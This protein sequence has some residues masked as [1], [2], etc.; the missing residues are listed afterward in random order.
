[1]AYRIVQSICLQDRTPYIYWGVQTPPQQITSFVETVHEWLM[2]TLANAERIEAWFAEMWAACHPGRHRSV[3]Q[4][5]RDVDRTA[6]YL[7]SDEQV[8]SASLRDYIRQMREL[9]CGTVRFVGSEG[10]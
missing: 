9:P 7:G 8:A 10:L 3:A 5:I 4:L 1:M 6:A 2:L